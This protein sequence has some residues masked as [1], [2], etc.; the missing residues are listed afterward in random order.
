MFKDL[1]F[2]PMVTNER[3]QGPCT[4]PKSHWHLMVPVHVA[5]TS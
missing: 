5:K 3:D 2:V 4:A 1:M